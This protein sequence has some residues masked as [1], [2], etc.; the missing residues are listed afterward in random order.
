LFALISKNESSVDTNTTVTKTEQVVTWK[1]QSD[2]L[3][4]TQVSSFKVC[5]SISCEFQNFTKICS[6]GHFLS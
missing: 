3:E 6:L 2:Y 4:E 5:L 1:N